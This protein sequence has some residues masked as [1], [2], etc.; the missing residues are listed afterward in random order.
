[1][2][3]SARVPHIIGAVAAGA[4]LIGAQ[5]AVASTG[6]RPEASHRTAQPATAQRQLVNVMTYDIRALTADGTRE[7]SGVI[8]PWA[9]RVRKQAKLIRNADSEVIA[10]QEGSEYVGHSKTERQVDSLRHAL[11]G[12][13]R[14]ARTE[15]PP[16]QP[17]FRTGDYIIYDRQAV[18]AVGKGGHFSVGS[19]KY[20]AYHEFASRATKAK[21]LFVCTHLLVGLGH[22]Y[23]V[24]REAETNR[25]LSK[26]GK[27]AR[28]RH[29][30][31]IYAGDFNSPRPRVGAGKAMHA[32]HARD[33]LAVAHT[34][35]NAGYNSDNDYLRKPP[36]SGVS[37]DHIYAPSGI[38]VASAGIVLHLRHGRFVGVIPSDHNPV[39]AGLLYP[40]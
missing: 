17:H 38:K 34:R 31:V 8:A 40:Y 39:V 29:V 15:V 33:A 2:N 37:I 1:M 27:I 25:I 24:T 14:L 21:F 19:Q 35:T 11:G 36:R 5:S 20:A 6:H 26:V 28:H 9:K 7:G 10:I 23:D 13:Y 32:A 12:S 18:K 3:R 4:L 16:G 22:S 30:P